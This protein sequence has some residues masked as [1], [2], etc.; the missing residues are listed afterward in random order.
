[1]R[2][3][4]NLSNPSP[5]RATMFQAVGLNAMEKSETCKDVADTFT[6]VEN[7]SIIAVQAERG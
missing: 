2:V 6:M 4:Y 3:G 5:F 7:A 1:M